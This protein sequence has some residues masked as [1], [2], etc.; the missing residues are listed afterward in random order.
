MIDNSLTYFCVSGVVI[1]AIL[2]GRCR[3]DRRLYEKGWREKR[4]RMDSLRQEHD[5]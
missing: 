2:L 5:S 4:E 3:L 1:L